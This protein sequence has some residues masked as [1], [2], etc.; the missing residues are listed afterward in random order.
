MEN[1]TNEINKDGPVDN[2]VIS[3]CIALLSGYFIM[4]SITKPVGIF[5]R[6]SMTVS[7]FFLFVTLFAFIWHKI[8]WK[9]R[10]G[11]FIKGRD[12][13]IEDSVKEIRNGL[14][15][16][17]APRFD[18]KLSKMII[19]ESLHSG[20]HP[21]D[22]DPRNFVEGDKKKEKIFQAIIKE[23]NKPLNDQVYSYSKNL[24]YELQG[25]HEKY[26]RKPLD[27]SFKRI[28]F[29]FDMLSHKARYLFFTL[30]IV[31]CFI[32]IILHLY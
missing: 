4:F 15:E 31:F 5:V 6:H 16:F 23:D 17:F 11:L 7:M 8:R 18:A 19:M 13:I 27:E 28:K 9:Y 26:F 21:K 12:K 25:L 14:L 29:I 3:T 30:G 2:Y 20:K 24:V 22:I 32:S 10:I 1:D